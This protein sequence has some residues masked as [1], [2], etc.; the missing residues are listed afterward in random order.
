L[1]QSIS[2]KQVS[3]PRRIRR[4]RTKEVPGEW[5]KLHNFYSSPNIIG[6]ITLGMRWVRHVAHRKEIQNSG[7]A[8]YKSSNL[9]TKGRMVL[10]W[11][12][13]GRMN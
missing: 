8:S 6:K 10:N 3:L 11:M 7:K 9:C 12:F 4:S 1:L 2:K 13:R 5:K